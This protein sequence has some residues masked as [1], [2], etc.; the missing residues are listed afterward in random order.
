[1]AIISFAEHKGKNIGANL[2]SG[3][4]VCKIFPSHPRK[5]ILPF[6]IVVRTGFEQDSSYQGAQGHPTTPQYCFSTIE[7]EENI[8]VGLEGSIQSSSFLCL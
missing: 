4:H 5:F 8:V 7:G 2:S 6:L 3:N 1:M